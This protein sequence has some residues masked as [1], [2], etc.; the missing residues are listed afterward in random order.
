VEI[1]Q[2]VAPDGTVHLGQVDK[3]RVAVTERNHTVSGTSKVTKRYLA[4]G[5]GSDRAYANC[6]KTSGH[7]SES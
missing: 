6:I 1:A 2:L 5:A 3:T 7:N 4:S